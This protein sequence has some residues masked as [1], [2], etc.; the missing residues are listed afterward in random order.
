MSGGGYDTGCDRSQPSWPI[1]R[2]NAAAVGFERHVDA[3]LGLFEAAPTAGALVLAGL[4]ARGAGD[5]ADRGIALRHE[6]MLGKLVSGR[7]GLEVGGR[8][9]GERVDLDAL[10]V[11]LEEIQP[12]ADGILEAL[13]AGEPGVEALKRARQRL[14]LA[15][16][17]AEDGVGAPQKPKGGG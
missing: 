10:A 4:H 9:V 12:R 13:A 11:G 2:S 14:G 17:A 16:M 6:R 7:M 1:E 3:A 8:P 5:A 15:G